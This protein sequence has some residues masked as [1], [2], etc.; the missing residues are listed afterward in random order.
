MAVLRRHLKNFL[1]TAANS[2][3]NKDLTNRTKALPD[4]LAESLLM[5]VLISIWI[6]RLPKP[7]ISTYIL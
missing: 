5:R 4:F 7:S 2:L 3:V 6:F 1:L